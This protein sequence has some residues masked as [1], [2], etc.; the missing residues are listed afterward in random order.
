MKYNPPIYNALEEYAENTVSRFHMPGHGGRAQD[1]FLGDVYRYD[2]T[3]L[4]ETDDLACPTGVIAEAQRLAAEKFGAES[5]LFSCQGATLCIRAAI[6]ACLML[7]PRGRIYCHRKVHKSVVNTFVLLDIRPVWFCDEDTDFSDC[8]AVIYTHTDYHGNIFPC[9]KLYSAAQKYGFL[10]VADNAHGSHLAFM[11]G[12]RLHPVR[13]GA[14]F[15]IDSLHKTLAVLTGGACLNVKKAEWSPL[16]RSGM[17]LFGSTSP[18]YLIMASIDKA[19]SLVSG[20][21]LDKTRRAVEA[22][23][24][25]HPSFF[26]D[27]SG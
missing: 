23:K 10:V 9:E 1:G 12:G 5:T 13:M 2:V 4:S 22:V 24:K 11:E 20:D 17:T 26:A 25:R 19:L 18:S 15:C 27:G 14:D 7:R 8:D 16:C 6:Y 21:V 3:E